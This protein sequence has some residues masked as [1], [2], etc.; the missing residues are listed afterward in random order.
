MLVTPVITIVSNILVPIVTLL[1]VDDADL[2]I[3]N[4]ERDRTEE[5]VSKVQSLLNIRN[6][7]LKLT[8]G[9]LKL[10]KFY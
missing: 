10:S 7:V 6:K 4:A 9:E 5:I 3:F 1:Y 8:G 2:K